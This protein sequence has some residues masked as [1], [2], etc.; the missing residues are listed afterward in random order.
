MQF[1]IKKCYNGL[2]AFCRRVNLTFTR[3][4]KL[5]RTGETCGVMGC[6]F[7]YSSFLQTKYEYCTASCTVSLVLFSKF[8]R[9]L[10]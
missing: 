7:A 6:E 1:F 5:L 8:G 2:M 4:K 10:V 9:V 3:D